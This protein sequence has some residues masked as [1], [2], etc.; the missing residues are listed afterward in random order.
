MFIEVCLL[1]FGACA[2]VDLYQKIKKK[3]SLKMTLR[4]KKN[5]MRTL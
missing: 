2:G 5:L 3:L 1:S 4:Q